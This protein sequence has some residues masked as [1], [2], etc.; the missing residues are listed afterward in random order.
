MSRFNIRIFICGIASILFGL[1]IVIAAFVSG[2]PL[3]FLS[4]IIFVPLGSILAFISGRNLFAPS[5]DPADA[6][7]SPFSGS[8]PKLEKQENRPSPKEREQ[9]M[10]KCGNC[11][12]FLEDQFDVCWN[13]CASREQ[14]Y[15]TADD[16][17]E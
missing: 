15:E 6:E 5:G 16:D 4:G 3:E 9:W 1:S 12:E 10:W 17:D 2:L 7:I 13:C 14:G 11:G 8:L